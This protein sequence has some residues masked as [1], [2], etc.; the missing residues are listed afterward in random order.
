MINAMTIV[1][2]TATFLFVVLA[3]GITGAII[4]C[5]YA[6]YKDLTEDK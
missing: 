2:W 6:G 3:L 1:T 4:G 5:L